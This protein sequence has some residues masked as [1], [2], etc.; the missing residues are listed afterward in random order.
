MAAP[1]GVNM[2]G[3]CMVL[4]CAIFI[5]SAFVNDEFEGLQ[6]MPVEHSF[7]SGADV[8][9]SKRGNIVIRSFKMNKAQF[10]P[11]SPLTAEEKRK[12]K[13]AA[14]LEDLY[15]LK[16]PVRPVS[17]NSEM[18]SAHHVVTFVLA[19]QLYESGLSDHITLN[20]DPSGEVI[21][22]SLSTSTGQCTGN[23]M[24]DEAISSWNTTVEIIQ[25][26]PGPVP[27]TQLYIDKLKR[28]EHDKQKG[29][30]GDN[31]SFFAKY[32]MY[33]VPSVIL[34]MLASNA[35]P[36]AAAGGVNETLVKT[37][38]QHQNS[39]FLMTVAVFGFLFFSLSLTLHQTFLLLVGLQ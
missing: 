30:Q 2:F 7:D 29:Q 8:S 22:V 32:W 34:L 21:S 11:A 37:A 26:V 15:L 23:T 18:E 19:C 12:L 36:Q 39:I 28:E 14:K 5:A 35:D 33:I 4:I 24:P 31:R 38:A 13:N 27:E 6:W 25:T 20:V 10:F 1:V 17:V 9:F 16:I 3:V